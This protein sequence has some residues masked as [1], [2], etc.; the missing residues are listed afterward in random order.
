MPGSKEDGELLSDTVNIID[1]LPSIQYG[2]KRSGI[3]LA[4]HR[5]KACGDDT[6]DNAHSRM[7]I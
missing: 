6:G 3:H 1:Q 4:A 5:I 2:E 7:A